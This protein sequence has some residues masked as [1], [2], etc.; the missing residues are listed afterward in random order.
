M[1]KPF[2]FFI[3]LLVIHSLYSTIEFDST[4]PDSLHSNIEKA[5]DKSINGRA[6]VDFYVSNF[7]LDDTLFED[8]LLATFTLQPLIDGEVLY[9]DDTQSF[10]QEDLENQKKEKKYIIRVLSKGEQQL[11]K[12][13][14]QEIER[15]L[16]YDTF[17]NGKDINLYIYDGTYS[18]HMEEENYR[19]G[20]TF[21]AKDLDNK[22]RG[23]FE[24][25]S[26]VDSLAL[27]SPLYINNMLPGLKIE[28]KSSFRWNINFAMDIVPSDY[29]ASF[30]V[31]Y[32]KLVYPITPKFG[33]AYVN[34]NSQSYYYV[35]L[36]ID[37]FL[38]FNTLF[39]NISFT[40]VEDARAGVSAS[41]LFGLNMD[42]KF[43]MDGTFSIFYE[44]RPLPHF[45]WRLGYSLL[46]GFK[47]GF[48]IGFGGDF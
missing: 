17:I 23:V 38:P 7:F 34:N 18:L 40:L 29:F 44:H 33:F 2:L 12:S 36:G 3:F 15:A 10:E 6:E 11:S 41:F 30:E 4:V 8:S 5:I 24:L 20:T 22:T 14:E 25:S 32:T 35:S 47:D 28:K 9:I 45:F 1:K 26:K 46:P 48:M 19:K 39:P 42:G 31:G 43:D 16:F 21:V 13:I 27:L 37:G